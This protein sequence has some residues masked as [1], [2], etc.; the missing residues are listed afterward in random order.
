MPAELHFVA[1]RVRSAGGWL[2]PGVVTVRDGRIASV[3]AG[4][5]PAPERILAAG[6][7]DLQ[8]NGHGATD[9]ATAADPAAWAAMDAALVSQGVTAWFPTLVSGPLTG[10]PGQLRR[11]A[12]WQAWSSSS[13]GRVRLA[14]VHLEGPF[15]GGVP[16]AHPAHHLR[17]PDLDFLAALP[18]LVR[19]V[20]LGPERP[21]ALEAIAHLSAR[22]VLVS[23]GHTAA[24]GTQMRAAAAAG[25]RLVTHLF[26]AMPP[27]HHRDPGAVGAALADPRLAVSLIADGHHVHLDAL[28]LAAAAKG[29]GR[30]VLVTDAS[31]WAAGILGEQAVTLVDGVPR[32][33]EGTLAGSALTMDRAVAV[34]VAAGIDLGAALDAASTTPAA[35][36]GLAGGVLQPGA[37]ADLVALGPDLTVEFTAVAGTVV[38]PAGPPR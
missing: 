3:R 22:G 13:A 1:E 18:P 23:L 4:S 33:A 21:G 16:G 38:E 24:S 29:P 17:P 31:A 26:N 36:A 6:F 28:A 37:P 32:L 25:A 7:V 35:L 5:G 8:V 15:L 20:T 14:G 34:A 12:A 30:F 2:E 9:A 19:I 27:F 10:Y 11:L